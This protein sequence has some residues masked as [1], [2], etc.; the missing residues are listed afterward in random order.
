[1]KAA[2]LILILIIFSFS[3]E[4]SIAQTENGTSLIFI[5]H[6]EK[7][8]NDAPDPQLTEK[9]ILQARHLVDVLKNVNIDAIY[10][11]KT[12]RTFST[13]GPLSTARKLDVI[14]Y[15][16]KTVDVKQLANVYQ[17]QTILI[18]GHSNST[19]KLVNTLLGIDKYPPID[20]SDYNNLYIVTV[21]DGVA[22]AVLLNIE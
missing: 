3:F 18:V 4:N 1:M 13:V 15:D 11:T 17:G 22:R 9:G 5:R 6:A 14:V 12:K 10:S 2:Q 19:P 16:A 21:V 8:Q 7:M 20:D